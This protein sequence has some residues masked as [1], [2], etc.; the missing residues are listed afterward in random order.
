MAPVIHYVERHHINDERWNSCIH[1]SCNGLIYA[2]TIYLDAM[3]DGQWAALIMDDYYAVMPLPY[4]RKYGISY[5]YQP[6]F[7]QQ[8]G[9]FANDI[10]DAG[11]IEKFIQHIPSK[12][13]FIETNFNAANNVVT[14][15]AKKRKNYLLDISGNYE[16]LKKNYSRSAKRNITKAVKSEIK[17]IENIPT[18]DII[19]LHRH[20]FNDSVGATK[21]DYSRLQ[22]LCNILSQQKNC[23]T[24]G[25]FDKDGQLIAGSIYWLYKNR[26]TFILNGNSPKSLAC[27]ATHFLKDAVIQKFAEKDLWIDFEGSDFPAFARFYEQFGN[28]EIEYYS[29]LVINKLPWPLKLFKK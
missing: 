13:L 9:V 8:S 22:E 18:S 23:Y 3:C 4:R 17:L 27:G 26:V 19:A 11:T 6:A 16:T 21:Q 10:T 12:F 5:I 24:A 2:T 7:T 29:T 15:A 25:A 1:T 28:T 20:R 14:Q